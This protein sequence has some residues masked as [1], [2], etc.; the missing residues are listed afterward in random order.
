[1]HKIDSSSSPCGAK[2]RIGVES[3]RQDWTMRRG[4]TTATTVPLIEPSSALRGA[5][6]VARIVMIAHAQTA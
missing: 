3:E 4:A 5:P 1:M 2:V 6:A